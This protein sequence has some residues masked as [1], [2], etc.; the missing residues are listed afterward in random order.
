[1]KMLDGVRV[2]DLTMWAFCPSAGAV[3]AEWGADVIH[4]ENPRS[5][6]P[7]RLMPGGNLEPGGSHWL[8]KHYN[9]GKRAITLDLA[10]EEARE[11]LY[12]LVR[13][14][15][16]FLTSF[17]PNT[18]QKLGFDIDQLRAI[19][20]NIIYAK[21]TGGGPLGP[22][23]HRGG[24]DGASWWL[25]G[26]LAATV[27][28]VTQTTTPS[29]MVGHGDGMSGLVFAGGI[30]AAL[31]KRERSGEA[32][33]VD[34]S[35][36]GTATWFNAPAIIAS[37][38]ETTPMM[39]KYVPREMGQWSGSTYR[40][41]DDRWLGLLHVGDH[42]S[43]FTILCEHLGRKELAVDTRF[44][45]Q[46]NRIA[47]SSELRGIMDEIFATKTL[48]EWKTILLT[49]KGVWAPAQTVEEMQD[50]VQVVANGMIRTV[51]YGD[52]QQPV[53]MPPIMFNEDAGPCDLAPNFNEHT[54]EVLQSIV[55]YDESKIAELRSAGAI[56]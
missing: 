18:R 19:N 29:G 11:V 16:V 55:G 20:P 35:L 15:D 46:S 51:N 53:I 10:N 31:F 23:S 5:P 9:R 34:S 6:D 13:E 7:M 27:M 49:S 1:M 40:T 45:D 54:D 38:V 21:G 37:A 30:V 48:A 28:D 22:E 47:N 52:S 17:L 14:S 26:S 41:A 42:D 56:A 8:F 36:L 33:V 25:R 39:G 4:I 3:L 2:L 50:D 32:V 24:Y 43:E 12:D 44:A